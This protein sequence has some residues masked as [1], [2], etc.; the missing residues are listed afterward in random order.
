MSTYKRTSLRQFVVGNNA[1]INTPVTFYKVDVTTGQRTSQLATVYN[2]SVGGE[3]VG[4]P[5][6][7]DSAGKTAQPL[8]IEEPV[9]AVINSTTLGTH[10]TGVIYPLSGTFRGDWEPN[11]SYLPG[12]LITDGAAG[13]DTGNIYVATII[14][15]STSS[16]AADLGTSWDLALDVS[17]AASEASAAAASA[18]AAAGSATAAATSAGAASTSAGAAAS[19]AT[20]A[21]AA[22]GSVPSATGNGLSFLRQNAGET[23]LEYRTP[24]QVRSDINA[25]EAINNYLIGATNPTVNNDGVDTAALG[26]TFQ[27]RSLWLNT[28]TS[29]FYI[30]LDNSTGAADWQQSTLTLDDLGSMAV[31]NASAISVTGGTIGVGVNQRRYDAQLVVRGTVNEISDQHVVT[32]RRATRL[33]NVDASTTTGTLTVAL[34]KN[35]TGIGGLT[36]VAITSTQTETAVNSSSNAYIDFA[37]GD[38]LSIDRSSVSAAENLEIWLDL[39]DR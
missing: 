38:K 8:Y 28:V 36:A 22:A 20:I 11:A 27:P 14:H 10:D 2:A 29:E 6:T 33:H 4:N 3:A 21:Q 30:C 9:I 39:E 24:A 1:Y 23:A 25:A 26:V 5:Y 34:K 13:N 16:F 7:L 18:T 35:G 12:D 31:Q 19:S 37:A 15:T 17:L 32:F